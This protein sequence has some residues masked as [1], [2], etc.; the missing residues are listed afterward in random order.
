MGAVIV[1][2]TSGAMQFLGAARNTGTMIAGNGSLDVQAKLFGTGAVD[3]GANGTVTLNNGADANSL[4]NFLADTGSLELSNPMNFLGTI[5]GFALGDSIDLRLVAA[6]TATLAGG[7]LTLKENLATV[8]KLHFSGS[9][10]L[11]DFHLG[12]DQHG[13]TTITHT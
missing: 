2:V 5:A 1:L 3:I 7:V 8:A 13:G 9:Y 6:N 4:A 12:S 10:S 11:A